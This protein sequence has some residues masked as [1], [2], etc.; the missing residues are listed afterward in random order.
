MKAISIRNPFAQLIVHG[1][2]PLEIR[3]K[4]TYYRGDILICAS[5]TR[6]YWH[7]LLHPKGVI[8]TGDF[9]SYYAST[10]YAI[11]IVTIADCREFMEEDEP[12][13]WRKYEPN[14]F[15]YVLE[16][17]RKIK[18]FPVAGNLGLFNVEV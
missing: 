9:D 15:A 11:G 6:V 18:P 16:N 14:L 8:L 1:Y 5:K 4:P 13:A 10:G 12:L 3:S 7:E 2:K 17:P